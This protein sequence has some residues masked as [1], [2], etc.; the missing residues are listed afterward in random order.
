MNSQQLD[1]LREEILT[2]MKQSR[3]ETHVLP[4]QHI[5][6]SLSYITAAVDYIRA[7]AELGDIA[8]CYAME[9]LLAECLI[10]EAAVIKAKQ[11]YLH[12]LATMRMVR[13]DGATE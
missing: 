3:A 10:K 8:G 9:R 13:G 12:I 6:M 5:L 11:D 4:E 7:A 2:L 1:E